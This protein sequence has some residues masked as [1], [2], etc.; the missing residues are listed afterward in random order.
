MTYS[1]K[2]LSDGA[3]DSG[4]MSIAYWYEDGNKELQF[5]ND[6]RPRV[7]VA[8][9][10]GSAYARSYSPQDYWTT[11]YVTE[12]LEETENMVKFKTTNSIYTWEVF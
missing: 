10:V 1:L 6:A 4:Q 12:I 8:M 3:G 11:T 7:G 2:R 9:R 5:E